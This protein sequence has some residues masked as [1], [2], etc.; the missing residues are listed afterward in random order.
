MAITFVFL[1]PEMKYVVRGNVRSGKCSF[2]EMSLGKL[3]VGGMSFRGVVRSGNCPSRK[4]LRGTVRCL[5]LL[6]NSVLIERKSVSSS[7]IFHRCFFLTAHFYTIYRCISLFI[8]VTCQV[9]CLCI[10]LYIYIFSLSLF[11]FF[12]NIF[13]EYWLSKVIDNSVLG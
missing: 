7:S 12:C 10:L 5:L 8:A 2:G 13:Q 6:T 1:K 11:F 4:C 9:Q 3:S